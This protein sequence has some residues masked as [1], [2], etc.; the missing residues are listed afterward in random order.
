MFSDPTPENPAD[1]PDVPDVPPDEP[2][3]LGGRVWLIF[4]IDDDDC[5][6]IFVKTASIRINAVALAVKNAEFGLMPVLFP[7]L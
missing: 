3:I 7:I 4:H 5:P 6:K 1:D 2:G